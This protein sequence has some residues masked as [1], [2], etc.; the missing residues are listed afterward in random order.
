ME[1]LGF[2]EDLSIQSGVIQE[3]VLVPQETGL[4]IKG[5]F[6]GFLGRMGAEM[7]REFKAQ[8]EGELLGREDLILS[9]I[10][11]FISKPKEGDFAQCVS[12]S[13]R[14]E[15]PDKDLLLAGLY[16]A[17]DPALNP[18]PGLRITLLGSAAF[19]SWLF[20]VL[21]PSSP[22]EA[23]GLLAYFP[24]VGVSLRELAEKRG[25]SAWFGLV[26]G[27][28]SSRKGL[29]FG[30]GPALAAELASLD[31]PGYAGFYSEARDD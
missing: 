11:P 20:L 29:L 4:G 19:G 22:E 1:V 30:P 2:K 12:F 26:W 16:M 28:A 18:P 21:K 6:E 3:G 10:S 17:L 23:A 9:R 7:V 5:A 13:V 8:A 24:G 25:F 15:R 14:L 27:P 31:L